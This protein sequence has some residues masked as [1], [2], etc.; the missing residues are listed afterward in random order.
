MAYILA[1]DI[2]NP[3]F[4]AGHNIWDG[5]EV[6]VIGNIDQHPELLK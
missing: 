1:K 6:E 4:N 5:C 3:K 2:K